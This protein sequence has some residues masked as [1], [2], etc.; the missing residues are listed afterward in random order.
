MSQGSPGSLRVFDEGNE[1]YASMQQDI[2]SARSAIR[3]ERY[4]PRHRQ[5]GFRP[6]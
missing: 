3:L 5:H 4:R 1:L 2:D 6:K